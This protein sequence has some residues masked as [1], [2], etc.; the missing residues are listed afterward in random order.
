MRKVRPRCQSFELASLRGVYNRDAKPSCQVTWS[1]PEEVSEACL[2]LSVIV[3][4]IY[5]GLIGLTGF[6]FTRVPSG[7]VPA[8]DKGY[9]LVNIQL[10]DSASLER[11][12]EATA[13]VEKIALDTPGVA[14]TVAIPGSSFVL[15]ANSSN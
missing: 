10:P 6:G 3:L 9:L 7:F 14:H 11:T 8:Q 12:V 15:N 5:I 13:A 4:L 2:R 1:V